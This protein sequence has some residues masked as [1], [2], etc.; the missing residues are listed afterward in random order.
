MSQKSAEFK[1]AI[2]LATSDRTDEVTSAAAQAQ[3]ILRGIKQEG[4]DAAGVSEGQA[5]Q[6]HIHSVVQ[7]F[8][9]TWQQQ[10]PQAAARAKALKTANLVRWLA[11]IVL[12]IVAVVLLFKAWPVAIVLAII[13]FV[14]NPIAA[15]VIRKK[16]QKL[17]RDSAGPRSQALSIIGYPL[18]GSEQATGLCARA[19]TLFLHSLDP[20]ALTIEQQRRQMEAM[21]AQ[22]QAQMAQQQEAMR[23][24]QEQMNRMVDEQEATNDALYG[25]PGFIG[26]AMRAADRAKRDKQ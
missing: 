15:S 25:K 19:D 16:A 5:I 21:Q 7:Q 12:L 20:N 1:R 23:Q 2:T 11:F 24:Q 10:Y 13:A 17:A 8:Q 22:H 3:A 18:Q 6:N 4:L 26:S 9:A 14:G